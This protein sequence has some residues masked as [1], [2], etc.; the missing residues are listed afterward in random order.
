MN[1][2]DPLHNGARLAIVILPLLLAACAARPETG[3]PTL[4]TIA[5]K[6]DEAIVEARRAGE[7]AGQAL[8]AAQSAEKSARAAQE[9]A[10]R[11][12]ASAEQAAGEA[13]LAAEKAERIFQR[14]LR[15]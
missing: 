11:A 13:R 10:E 12:A 14:S 3:G 6:A 15:K 1:K 8:A 9:A 2:P 7:T 4:E 5:A